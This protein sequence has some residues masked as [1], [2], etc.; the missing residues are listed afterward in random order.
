[1]I[2]LLYLTCV[3]LVVRPFFS[4]KVMVICQGQSQVS[5]SCL[6]F[7]FLPHLFRLLTTLK[8]MLFENIV[9]KGENAGNQQCFLPFPKQISIFSFSF[10]I[11]PANAFNFD[12][13]I[14]LTFGKELK[15]GCFGGI[16]I[17]ECNTILLVSAYTL[18][19]Y[20]G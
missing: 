16:T 8:K 17:G 9:G 1:M 4:T 15:S 14:I 10:H 11:S 13:F 3:F 6:K 12:L 5:R 2:Q 7:N 20:F 19:R 18:Y